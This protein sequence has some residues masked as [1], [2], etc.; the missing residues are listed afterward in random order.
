MTTIGYGDITPTSTTG[1]ILA[2]IY[3][4]LA[5]IAL[6]DAVSDVQMIGL[7]RSIRETDF[8]KQMDECLLRDAVREDPMIPNETPVL[9]EAEFLIDQLT[10][11]EIVDGAA[12]TA[13]RRQFRYITRNGEF[14]RDEDRAL[15]P[16]LVFEELLGRAAAGKDLSEGAAALDLDTE[17]KFKWRTYEEWLAGSWR[18]RVGA[19]GVAAVKDSVQRNKNAV[20]GQGMKTMVG[21]MHGRRMH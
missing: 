12:V 1:K 10:S 19:A 20:H 13:I 17:G 5:V 3:L 15:T 21:A 16:R 6:A 2:T 9:S 8:G 7:R 18:L 14:E 4:P 11:N